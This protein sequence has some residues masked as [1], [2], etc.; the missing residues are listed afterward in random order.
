MEL[1]SKFGLKKGPFD[2]EP[3]HSVQ[4]NLKSHSVYFGILITSNIFLGP[5]LTMSVRHSV[6]HIFLY[7]K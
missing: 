5:F 6:R 3:A 7:D 2:S 1:Q 4:I